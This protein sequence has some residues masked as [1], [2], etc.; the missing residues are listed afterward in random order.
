M[1]NTRPN[2]IVIL[3]DDQGYGDLSC[4]GAKD[5]NTPNIDG[6]AK[7]GAKFT[8]FYAQPVCGPSRAALLTGSY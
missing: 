6:M 2:F 8:D 5:I 4:F 7:Q 1:T 3:T